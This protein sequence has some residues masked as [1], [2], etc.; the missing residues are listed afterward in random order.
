MMPLTELR[1]LYHGFFIFAVIRNPWDRVV[2]QFYYS[3]QHS[4]DLRRQF[5]YQINGDNRARF[6]LWVKWVSQWWFPFGPMS[7]EANKYPSLIPQSY[8]LDTSTL[9]ALDFVLRFEC[10]QKDFNRLLKLL[11][12]PARHM[13]AMN[14]AAQRV[15]DYHTCYNDS[16]RRAI[17]SI[18]AKDVELLGYEF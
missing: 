9:A 18:F 11:G 13:P 5:G 16:T 8:F 12:L 3:M 6:R 10:L 1:R 17:S 2:S 4:P 14:R 15:K 7:T